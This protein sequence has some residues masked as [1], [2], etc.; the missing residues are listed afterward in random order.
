MQKKKLLPNFGLVTFFLTI[1]K[2]AIA[3]FSEF[4]DKTYLPLSLGPDSA[5]F[6]VL[7]P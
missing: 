5:P 6:W 4:E 1:V 3:D 2:A 7:G